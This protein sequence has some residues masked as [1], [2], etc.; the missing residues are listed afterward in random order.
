M[1]QAWACL[2]WV[3]PTTPC[4][5]ATRIG[6]LFAE[7]SD[8]VPAALHGK[9][10]KKPVGHGNHGRPIAACSQ[11]IRKSKFRD[12]LDGLSNTIAMGE[13]ATDLGDRDIR[14]M[15]VQKPNQRAAIRDNPKWCAEVDN[16]NRSSAASILASRPATVGRAQWAWLP[17]GGPFR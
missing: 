9:C 13:I 15:P 11:C 6:S 16:R 4:A 5:L 14:T 17:L 8:S 3:E 10:M 2:R 1:I 12:I 7:T